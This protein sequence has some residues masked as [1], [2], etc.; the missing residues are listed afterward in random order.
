MTSAV[1]RTD[2]LCKSYGRGL[3]VQDLDFALEG[4][5]V[6][7][8]LGPNGAGK[9]TVLRM[10]AGLL[11]PTSGTATVLS[12]DPWRSPA[13]LH[14]HM[15]YLPGDL[16]LPAD[17]PARARLD[18]CASLRRRPPV[19]RDEL[20]ERLDVPLDTPLGALS[21]GNRQKVGIV[22]ALMS[23]PPVLLLDEP[24]SGLDPLAQ[25]VVDALV[26]EAAADGA[27]V[28]LSSHVLSEVDHVADQ[29]AML[30]RGRLM[31]V[32]RLSALRAAA[33]HHV[34]IRTSAGWQPPPGVNDLLVEGDTTSFT[35]P[36]SLLDALVTSLAGTHVLD[37]S[38]QAADLETLFLARYQDRGGE[39]HAA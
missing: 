20:V 6:V 34:R 4:G 24:T 12:Y 30:R 25:E 2:A 23:A 19:L 26:R 3:A 10:L 33:P 39:D 11:R 37:L 35:A 38:I 18:L 22:Q 29:A 13:E 1:V 31:G 7:G 16:R 5:Q 27:L 28:L 32:E 15:G 36:A 9:T 21:K 8:F 17:L 14:E